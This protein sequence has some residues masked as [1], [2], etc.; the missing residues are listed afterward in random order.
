MYC[1]RFLDFYNLN[2]CRMSVIQG[3]NCAER[4]QTKHRACFAP[5]NYFQK[6]LTY[7]GPDWILYEFQSIVNMKVAGSIARKNLIVFSFNWIEESLLLFTIWSLHCLLNLK[8]TNYW[9]WIWSI[10]E[11]LSCMI[12]FVLFVK[13]SEIISNNLNLFLSFSHNLETDMQTLDARI[14]HNMVL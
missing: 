5:K 13:L 9:S 12:F 4:G 14:S 3:E 6:T 8:R 2:V 1:E 7:V 11:I 10:L